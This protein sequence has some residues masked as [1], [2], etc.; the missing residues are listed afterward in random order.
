MGGDGIGGTSPELS[1]ICLDVVL[2]L[3]KYFAQL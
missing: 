2:T 3:C 1:L